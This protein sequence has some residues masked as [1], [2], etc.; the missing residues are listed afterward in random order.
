M[1]NW[2]IVGGAALIGSSSPWT[3]SFLYPASSFCI[4]Y[5]IP[6][7]FIPTAASNNVPPKAEIMATQ[8]KAWSTCPIQ[9]NL[10]ICFK[11]NYPTSITEE[12]REQL[13]KI[14]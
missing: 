14:L 9:G 8:T 7:S 5:S 6:G 4:S 11:I 1:Y 10:L 12:Q 2:P 13:E 3:S